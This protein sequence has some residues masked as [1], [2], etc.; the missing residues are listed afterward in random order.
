MAQL[1][2]NIYL[3]LD[4]IVATNWRQILR[5]RDVFGSSLVVHAW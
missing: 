3:V 5:H 4:G 2:E 1:M